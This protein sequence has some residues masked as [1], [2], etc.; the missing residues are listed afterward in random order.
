MINWITN[1]IERQQERKLAILQS[2]YDEEYRKRAEH[3]SDIQALRLISIN[4][5]RYIRSSINVLTSTL[6]SIKGNNGAETRKR[7]EFTRKRI[8]WLTNKLPEEEGNSIH[9]SSL[10]SNL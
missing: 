10:L 2:E 8:D 5:I 7:R 4:N 1:I 6:H 3:K 9:F